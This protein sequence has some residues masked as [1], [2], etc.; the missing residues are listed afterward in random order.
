MSVNST[1]LQITGS[2]P[3]WGPDARTGEL[4]RSDGKTLDVLVRLLRD[5]PAHPDVLSTLQQQ[6]RTLARCRNDHLLRLINV[7]AVGTNA[8][9][10]YVAFDGVSLSQILA[11]QR[12]RGGWLPV[13]VCMELA[14]QVAEGVATLHETIARS[15]PDHRVI[16]HGPSAEDVLINEAG[17]VRI[18]RVLVCGP[19]DPPATSLTPGYTPPEGPDSLQAS[20]YGLGALT[21]ALLSTQPPPPALA[22]LRR[23]DELLRQCIHALS[24]RPGEAVPRAVAQLL[25]LAMSGNHLVRPSTL[26]MSTQLSQIASSMRGPGIAAWAGASVPRVQRALFEASRT[27]VQDGPPP[28]R[29]IP[30]LPRAPSPPPRRAG[31]LPSVAPPVASRRVE[32]PEAVDDDPTF[33]QDELP[34]LVPLGSDAEAT[35]ESQLP[36]GFFDQPL[37]ASSGGVGMGLFR[38]PEV[39]LE[40]DPD[41]DPALEATMLVGLGGAENEPTSAMTHT[42]VL[43]EITGEPDAK[44]ETLRPEDQRRLMEPRALPSSVAPLPPPSELD[45]PAFG[46][47]PS[48]VAPM[49]ALPPAPPPPTP[50]TPEAAPPPPA[51]PPPTP[52]T[53]RPLLPPPPPR[54]GA[55]PRGDAPHPGG[56]P[57]PARGWR[58]G[59]ARAPRSGRR[60]GQPGPRRPCAGRPR[61]GRTRSG[62]TRAG[63]PEPR[64]ARER[65]PC[66]GRPQRQRPVHGRP[67]DGRP[68]AR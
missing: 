52:W 48:P 51:P 9:L 49:A 29:P 57:R 54:A 11:A 24:R 1:R 43:Q 4:T 27:T 12:V 14:A 66:A 6:A 61:P 21:L 58:R 53:P 68:G 56:A 67:I 40:L 32:V 59:G 38:S 37:P 42:D 3:S 22:D 45:A 30:D 65:G 26:A 2:A 20:V 18:A 15:A 36:A 7:S 28:A 5:E 39:P 60:R 17:E 33:R 63:R 19:Q 23:H 55:S 44:T 50:W 64:R 13:K 25:R 62:R 16:T 35:Q 10:V 31:P 34:P 47:G 46:G 8:A 41:L